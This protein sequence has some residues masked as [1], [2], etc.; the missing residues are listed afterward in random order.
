MRLTLRTLLA[1]V[2]DILEPAQ[3]REIGQK[4][5][6][7][8][9][10]RQLLARVREAVRKR[11]LGAPDVEGPDAG[12]DPNTVAEYLDNTLSPTGVAD[13]ERV[14]LESDVHLAEVAACHQILT[15]VLGEPVD[16]PIE[17]RERVYALGP[18]DHA[19]QLDYEDNGRDRDRTPEPAHPQ[20]SPSRDPE[21]FESRIPD[22]L[23]SDET[24]WK[25]ML[26]FIVVGLVAVGWFALIWF[27][28]TLNPFRNAPDG[29]EV[30]A[31]DP[32]TA[33]AGDGQGGIDK[34]TVP[35]PQPLPPG[36][37]PDGPAPQPGD[38]P[39]PI[40]D[41]P[42]GLPS[43]DGVNPKPP[44]D[45]PG[46][47]DPDDP[48]GGTT[49]ADAGPMP[50][51]PEPPEPMPPTPPM[52]G[53]NPPAPADMTG[54]PLDVVYTSLAGVVLNREEADGDWAILPRRSI[55]H[56]GESIASPAPF[57]ATLS[58]DGQVSVTLTWNSRLTLRQPTDEAAFSA[59][60]DTGRFVF[61][62][63]PGDPDA[64]APADPV[65]CLLE[66]HGRGYALRLDEPG[67]TCGI[68]VD[69]GETS[70]RE[71]VVTPESFAAAVHLVSGRIAIL[72]LDRE[73]ARNPDGTDARLA[74]MTEPG[75]QLSLSP[76]DWPTVST[77]EGLPKPSPVLDTAM[78]EWLEGEGR[79]LSSTLRRA[80][81]RF[82]RAFDA[83]GS[84]AESLAPA[85]DDANPE[86]S[87]YAVEAIA[88]CG[89]PLLLV[90]AL[91]TA[92]HPE[93][94]E[95]AIVGLRKWIATHPL[96][97][98]QTTLPVALETR[99]PVDV[100]GDVYKMLWGF[101]AEDGADGRIS[102]Q[103][104]DGLGHADE[105]VRHLAFF[106][107]QRLTGKT[108]DYLPNNPPAQ[109]ASSVRRWREYVLA[110]GALVTQ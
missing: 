49:V 109:R 8:E 75:F 82:E 63:P 34:G 84:A 42:N 15:L 105:A 14:C 101:D 67:T 20:T 106:H 61:E 98:I 22:Y 85:I 95:A 71:E 44:V 88:L 40:P 92:P 47:D 60:L 29:D 10:A 103:L 83:I 11:R 50:G 72:S 41:D 80:K 62:R 31:N 5:K 52:P 108:F 65:I 86:V 46:L 18:L 102:A 21:T 51:L 69:L 23:R 17:S 58:K 39:R 16:V 70:G 87:K 55:V 91:A 59:V 2:D 99:F 43:G 53:D 26:P 104:V 66:I 25:G 76:A 7:S 32:D 30:A 1:Y 19:P 37:G 45:E 94:R 35:P 27:D 38:D 13:V 73:P 97:E 36:P 96:E 48:M 28:P 54:Q 24:T 78:P 77:G 57:D 3:A 89:N 33:D 9:V 93:A 68:S 81:T 6:E 79:P 107:I 12:L 74:T 4:I 56:V 64:P 110:N 100:A 90:D